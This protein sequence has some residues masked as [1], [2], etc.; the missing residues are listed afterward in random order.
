LKINENGKQIFLKKF[1][2]SMSCRGKNILKDFNDDNI[3]TGSY[4]HGIFM[5]KTDN[6]GNYK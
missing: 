3:I 1:G 4:N 5:T 2:S 6:D